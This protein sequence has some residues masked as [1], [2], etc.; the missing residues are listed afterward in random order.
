MADLNTKVG[1]DSKNQE[2]TMGTHGEGIMNENGELFCD[3]CATN[4]L[5]I[6]E[7]L[8]PHKKSHKITWTSPDGMTEKQI[9]HVAINKSAVQ[10]LNQTIT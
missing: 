4:G 2:M 6:G 9:D 7:Q 3:F 10:M 8:F 5:V 1:S